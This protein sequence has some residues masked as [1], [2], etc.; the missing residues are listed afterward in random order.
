VS[1]DRITDLTTVSTQELDLSPLSLNKLQFSY[2]CSGEKSDCRPESVLMT[3]TNQSP[4][5]A[6]ANWCCAGSPAVIFVADGVRILAAHVVW[7][8]ETSDRTVAQTT[9]GATYL[10]FDL[11]SR[12]TITGTLTVEQY[13]KLARAKTVELKVGDQLKAFKLATSVDWWFTFGGQK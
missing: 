4:M 8:G 7:K 1:Y 13:Q 12:E 11:A 9:P 6:G 3:F 5:V 2:T 10:D